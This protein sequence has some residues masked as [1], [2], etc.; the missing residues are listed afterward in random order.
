MT[1]TLKRLDDGR[2]FSIFGEEV[3]AWSVGLYMTINEEH[4][5]FPRARTV[6]RAMRVYRPDSLLREHRDSLR[7]IFGMF[8]G[9]ARRMLLLLEE[10]APELRIE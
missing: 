4:A 8:H 3:L 9:N 2:E 1:T 7:G 10:E 5:G 6:I